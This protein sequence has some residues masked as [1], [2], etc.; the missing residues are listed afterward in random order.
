M[1]TADVTTLIWHK[2]ELG[3]GPR[4][5]DRSDKPYEYVVVLKFLSMAACIERLMDEI[6]IILVRRQLCFMA[7]RGPDSIQQWLKGTY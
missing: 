6:Q 4:R 7:R 1:D 5:L 2:H 3:I